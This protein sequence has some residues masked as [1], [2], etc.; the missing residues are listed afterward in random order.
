MADTIPDLSISSEKVCFVVL[1][2][3]EFDVKDVDTSSDEDG[4]NRADDGL[5]EVLEDRPD[6]PVEQELVAFIEAM[7]EDEQVDL[8][9]LAWLGRGDG[10]LADWADLRDEAAAAH[11]NRTASYLLGMPLLPDYL[12]DALAEFGRSCEE[13][14]KDHL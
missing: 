10:T 1:K 8:V 6:D 4:S 11:N 3:R 5:I 13:F 9:T 14:E 7:S 2:A 12:E